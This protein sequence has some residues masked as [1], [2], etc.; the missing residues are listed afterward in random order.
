MSTALNKEFL[1]REE[2]AQY[3]R[4]HGLPL[5]R[6]TLQKYATVGGGPRYHRFGHRAVYRREYLDEWIE[7]KL[8]EPAASTSAR[9]AV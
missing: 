4:D 7:E 2:A 6:N 5:S 1:N 9:A 3:V 8:G